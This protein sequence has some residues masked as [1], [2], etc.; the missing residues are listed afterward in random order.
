M[1][2]I[3]VLDHLHERRLRHLDLLEHEV[4]VDD[5]VHSFKLK[6]DAVGPVPEVRLADGIKDLPRRH[7]LR[8]PV[9]LPSDR[10]CVQ[11]L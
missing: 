7:I 9:I 11:R 2:V 1:L 4:G 3:D 10:C 8:L 6:I 5:T